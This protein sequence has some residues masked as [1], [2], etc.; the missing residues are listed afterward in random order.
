[1][2]GISGVISAYRQVDQINKGSERTYEPTSSKVASSNSSK[3]SQT[4]KVETKGF[5]PIDTK[6]SLVPK[7][8]EYGNTIGDVKLSDKAKDYYNQLKG[9]FHNMEFIAVSKDMKAQVHANA[10]AYGNANKMVVLIDEE[11]LERMA[12]DESFRKKYEGIIAMSQTKMAEAKN[13]LTSS[14]ASV[15]NFGMSVDSNGKENFFA[16]V[17]KSQDLQKKRIEKKAAEKKEQK[18]KEK[19]KAEKEAREERLQK[20]KDKK[21]DKTADEEDPQNIDDG[22][23]YVTIEAKSMDELLSKVQK[24]SYSEALNR[25]FTDSERMVGGHV[26]FRG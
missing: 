18:A 17:E 13:S 23:E 6:S 21:T 24:Y 3:E 5:T 25:V 7:T 15:K 11:K 20:A 4:S 14:G 26:D 22:K 2:A 19:K 12:T 9:K 1:M 16:T 10:A 8:T